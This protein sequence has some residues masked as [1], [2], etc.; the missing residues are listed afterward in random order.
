MKRGHP[1]HYPVTLKDLQKIALAITILELVILTVLILNKDYL[2]ATC[3]TLA[4]F[5]I[6]FAM[7]YTCKIEDRRNKN[8]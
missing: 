2:N 8:D 7:Y 3:P 5:N 4:I 1:D 6:T